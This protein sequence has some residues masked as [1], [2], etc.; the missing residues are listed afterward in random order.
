MCKECLPFFPIG[1]VFPKFCYEKL[2]TYCT[3]ERILQGAAIH[4][5]P[6]GLTVNSFLCASSPSTQLS[7]HRIFYAFPLSALASIS[8]SR[9]HYLFIVFYFEVRFVHFILVKF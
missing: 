9:G 5:P 4:P 3:T 8:L 7:V 1:Y 2:K 6:A